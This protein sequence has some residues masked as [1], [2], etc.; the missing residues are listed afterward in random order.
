[1]RRIFLISMIPFSMVFAQ[2]T[3]RPA[4]AAMRDLSGV[5]GVAPPTHD[6]SS[7]I[8]RLNFTVESPP[9]LPWAEERY[10]TFRKGT[11]DFP[12]I[13]RGDMDP[14]QYPYC[15]PFGM[16]RVYGVARVLEIVQGSAGVFVHFESNDVQ[17]I[18]TD[19]RPLP[20]GTPLSFMGRSTGKWVG[21]TLVAQTI[22]LNEL[23]WLDSLGHP[24]SDALRVE[25]RF[26]RV[27]HDTLEIEFKFDDPKTYAKPWTAKKVYRLDDDN[28]HVVLEYFRC[29]DH[30]R[31][32]YLIHALGIKKGS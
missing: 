11:E 3:K 10:K 7:R 27:K 18:Y 24:H 13:G 1:M 8:L 4:A 5:W 16:P 28:R 9:M 6:I 22:D 12:E 32:D 21:D 31:E 19:G 25:Q 14:T 2:S 15:M 20:E 30:T 26:R 17:R 29:E 23:S